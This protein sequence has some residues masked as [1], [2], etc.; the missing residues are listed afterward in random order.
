VPQAGDVL[1]ET[2]EGGFEGW[3]ASQDW[4]TVSGMLVNDGTVF[5]YNRW[6][7]APFDLGQTNDYAIEAEIQ[8]VNGQGIYGVVARATG[9][10]GYRVGVNW[11]NCLGGPNAG[12]AESGNDINY[13]RFLNASR[14]EAD[15]EWHTYRAE[16]QGNTVKFLMDGILLAET[17][18]NQFLAGGQVGLFSSGC[19]ISVRSFRVIAL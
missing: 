16:V 7:K 4:A 5:D 11:S 12:V 13:C 1:Y 8:F 6:L 10:E 18:D 14:W 17:I 15:T 19:Q 2:G 9:D 3:P